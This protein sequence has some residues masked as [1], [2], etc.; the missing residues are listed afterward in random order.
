LAAGGIIGYRAGDEALTRSIEQRLTALREIKRQRLDAYINN[1]LRTT[2]AVGGAPE[3]IEATKAFIAAFREMRAAVAS[4]PTEAKADSAA[5]EAW[6]AQDLVPRLDKISG[7]HQSLE[8]L[9]P[10]DLVARRLQADYIARNPNHVGEKAKLSAAPGGSPYDVAH[11]RFH[12]VMKRVAEAVGFYDINLMDAETGDVVYTVAKETDFA[13][14]MYRGAYAQSGFARVAQRA[15]DRRNGGAAVVEDYTPYPPSAFAPQMFTAVPITADGRT[16]GV[17]VAQIDINTLNNL[18]TDNNRWRET[19]QG[20]TGEVLLV[21]EDR[22][23]RSRS[24]FMIEAPDKFLEQAEANGLPEATAN[25]IRALGTVILYMPERTEAIERAFRN[26]TGL[27]RYRDYRGVEVISAYGPVEVAGLRWAI[28]AKQDVAEALAP[29]VDLRRD[30]LIA[31]AAAA[32][33]LTFLALA[34]AALFMRPLRRI[35]DGMRSVGEDGTVK[36]VPVQSGDEF[37]ELARGYNGMVDAIDQRDQRLA[38][39]EKEKS[40]LLRAIYPE[41]VAERIRSGAEITAETISNITVA[42]AWI[43]GLELLAENLPVTET[44]DRLSSLHDALSTAAA[45]HGVELVRSLGESYI[46]I[47]GLSSP[48]LDHA[49]RSLAWTRTAAL[50]VERLGD[51]W[52]KSV[53]VR[54]GLASGD[55]DV[56]MMSRGHSAY[57]IW[58][59]TLGIAR[60]I[61][62]ETLLG[63]VRVDQSTYRLLTDVEGFEPAPPLENPAWGAITSWARRAVER[64]MARAAE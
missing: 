57:D 22:L 53:S 12:P 52:A 26:Q 46:G 47:C 61:A 58:G 49:A 40:E 34:C 27:A 45:A 19:G 28:S 31:A 38:A 29:A 17:F 48:R 41:G 14:N 50:A 54:F 20:E 60:Y 55:I 59:R 24:R 33:A 1:Q 2:R 51:D 39:A 44:R 4:N 5:V 56:L 30:L 32:I 36:R 13:S 15:L 25:Q 11:A 21:G 16:I 3:T 37:G 35:L 42:V 7:G 64:E 23:L 8:G 6:Y 18:M 9:L 10:A 63:Y 43:D 62:V